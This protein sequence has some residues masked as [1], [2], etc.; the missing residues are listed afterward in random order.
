MPIPH[1]SDPAFWS[2]YLFEDENDAL[3]GEEQDQEIP[4]MLDDGLGLVLDVGI[5]AGY[6]SL[7]LVAPGLDEPAEVAWDDQAHW[8]PHLFRWSEL[9][10][11]CRAL[12][13]R[14][15]SLPH[16]GAPLALL[17][18][19]AFLTYGDDLDAITPLLEAAFAR[20]KPADAPDWPSARDWFDRRD[21]RSSAVTW[22]ENDGHWTVRQDDDHY[23]LYS[24]RTEDNEDFPFTQWATLM[25]RAEE[26]VQTATASWRAPLTAENPVEL[27]WQAEEL[28]GLPRGAHIASTFGPSPLATATTHDLDL[29]VPGDAGALAVKDAIAAALAPGK[30]GAAAITGSIMTKDTATDSYITK[31]TTVS[32]SVRDDLTRAVRIIAEVLGSHHV[33][34][35]KLTHSSP[36]VEI[37][38]ETDPV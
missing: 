5:S 10:L 37:P 23:G 20:L 3:L 31:E 13:L 27:A 17:S 16:P 8:H 14:D 2:A 35:A 9:D 32:I 38:L 12:A 1:L 25:A 7:A 28:N 6:H 18:R 4:F 21:L 36:P 33:T 26:V 15:P 30:L 11:F 34:G 29:C 19:F 24:L 22:D